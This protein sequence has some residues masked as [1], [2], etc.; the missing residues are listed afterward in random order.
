MLTYANRLLRLPAYR[1]ALDTLANLEENRSF[2]RHDLSHFLDVARIAR[3]LLLERALS[4]DPDDLYVAAL[5]HDLGRIAQM[6][7]GTPHREAGIPMAEKFLEAINFPAERRGLILAAVSGHGNENP[8][9]DDAFVAL[10]READRLS[11]PCC[12]CPA[13]ADC[14]WPDTKKNHTLTY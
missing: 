7:D 3:I 1:D 9:P 10:F 5:L 8:A 11:R 4:Y 2:C 14:Y 12:V 6:R 13:A